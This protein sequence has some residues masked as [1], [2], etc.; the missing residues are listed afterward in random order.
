MALFSSILKIVNAN[1][2]FINRKKKSASFS[3]NRPRGIAGSVAFGSSFISKSKPIGFGKKL[4]G[5]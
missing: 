1:K 4:L 2:G 5:E 3:K